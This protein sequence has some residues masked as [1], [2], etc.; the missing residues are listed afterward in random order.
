MKYEVF[1]TLNLEVFIVPIQIWNEREKIEKLLSR[2]SHL[3]MIT[4]NK[5][6]C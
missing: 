2:M 5:N 6:V 4:S 3:I 1:Y